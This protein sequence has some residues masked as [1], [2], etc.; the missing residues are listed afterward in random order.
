MTCA[1]DFSD[2][3]IGLGLFACFSVASLPRFGLV[4]QRHTLTE[5]ANRQQS[6]RICPAGT[7]HAY[8]PHAYGQ[9]TGAHS[10]AL[11]YARAHTRG[12]SGELRLHAVM[13]SVTT[14]TSC[15]LGDPGLFG[16]ADLD[17][18][19]PGSTIATSS[20]PRAGHRCPD[21]LSGDRRYRS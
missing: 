12:S 10:D 13:T 15:S 17:D 16:G 1:R 6:K 20:L 3:V 5:R 2:D 7:D 14:V 11:T 19:E 9:L 21:L 4:G 8:A 18:L